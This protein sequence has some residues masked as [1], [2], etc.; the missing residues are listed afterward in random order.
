MSDTDPRVIIVTGGSRGIGRAAALRFAE[1]NPK[2]IIVHYDPDDSCSNE[3]LNILASMGVEAESHKVD[4]S[5]FE[6]VGALFKDILSRYKKIDVL[7]NNAGITRDTLL[8]RMSEDDWD[9]VIR[10]NLKSVFN[11]TRAIVRPMI[12]QRKGC[13]VNISSVVGQ[14]GN[15]GQAN[16]S[17]SK[18]GIL[19]FTK[20]IAREVA[21]RGVTVNAVAPGFIDTEMTAVLSE[22]VKENLR[23]N[24]PLGRMGKPEDIAEAVY[25][26]C[27]EAANYIT[28]QV[29]HVNGGMYM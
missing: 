7:V 11:C 16:Y 9:T 28:G 27:S 14:I 26:L 18:A 6:A 3:T 21:A 1:D 19:G 25:W 20:T 17:A 29:I 24:I 10:V 22:K 15:P 23:L 13:I 5:S 8:M 12:K 4:V 2:I